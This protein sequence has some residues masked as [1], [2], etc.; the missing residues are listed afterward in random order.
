M[1]VAVGQVLA[2]PKKLGMWLF[3]V[4][5]ALTFT[6]LIVCYAYVR[7]ASPGWP[8]PFDFSPGILFSTLMTFV[9]LTSSLTMVVAVDAMRKGERGRT[10]AWI[11]ATMLC[12]AGF[13]ALH[14]T[15]WG[16]LI[17]EGVT[18]RANPWGEP[19]FGAA[20]FGLTG[21]HMAHVASGIV[22]LGILGA[23]VR[24]G[25]FTEEDI[26]VGGLYWHFVDLVW[27]FLFPLLYLTAVKP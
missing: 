13:I 7:L 5:D 12:G 25:R 4:S 22:Y 19:L 1:S 8:K 24:M 27:M 17:A 18:L 9:L 2:S 11:G 16:H 15:E 14:M 26:E 20:F 21:L 6:T 23:G 10:A 3:L